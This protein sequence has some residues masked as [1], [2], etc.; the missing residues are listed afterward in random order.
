MPLTRFY[1]QFSAFSQRFGGGKYN[2]TVAAEFRFQRIQDSIATNPNFSFVS[3]RHATAYTESVFP[4]LFFVDGRVANGQLDLNVARGFFQNS[5]MPEGFFRANRSFGFLT[6]DLSNGI[7]R[8]FRSHPVQPGRNEGVGNY[9]LHPTSPNVFD[10]CGTY[11][12]FVNE[13]VR[14]L[15]PNPTDPLRS[16]LNTNLDFFFGPLKSFCKQVFLFG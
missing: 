16:S 7:V 8:V 9:V 10:I 13:T 5:Q 12:K 2:L 1:I 14:S 6:P 3:P 11:T 15:Y 4:V